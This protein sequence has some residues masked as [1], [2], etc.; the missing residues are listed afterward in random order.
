MDKTPTTHSC[1]AFTTVDAGSGLRTF[2]WGPHNNTQPKWNMCRQG[3][4]HRAP[5]GAAG[6][7]GVGGCG[8]SNV[9]NNDMILFS[10]FFPQHSNT[11]LLTP[12]FQFRF[13]VRW[14][15]K[16][17]STGYWCGV[18][19]QSNNNIIIKR[20]RRRRRRSN[21]FSSFEFMYIIPPSV[22]E[23][24][25]TT[26][27][28]QI[29]SRKGSKKIC[30]WKLFNFKQLFSVRQWYNHH[31]NMLCLDLVIC[32]QISLP[33]T[34]PQPEPKAYARKPMK[35]NHSDIEFIFFVIYF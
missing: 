11:F 15:C 24:S 1:A 7:G 18:V 12:F 33:P 6:G 20:R 9:N 27:C 25:N 14:K 31:N 34:Q 3:N 23:K 8:G 28:S 22:K 35:R 10:S 13:F 19:L 32:F 2:L 30:G 16:A 29:L 5:V 17:N 21:T 26:N 4:T